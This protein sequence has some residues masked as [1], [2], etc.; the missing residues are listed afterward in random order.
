MLY[1][2]C[3]KVEAAARAEVLHYVLVFGCRCKVRKIFD[4]C[5][6]GC[7]RMICFIS[8]HVKQKSMEPSTMISYGFKSNQ[9][10]RSDLFSL[11]PHG[12]S[13]TSG[14]AAKRKWMNG[15]VSRCHFTIVVISVFANILV[16][17]ALQHYWDSK[18]LMVFNQRCLDIWNVIQVD[19]K[20]VLVVHI[21]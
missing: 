14:S 17:V 19:E 8:T 11:C 7:G 13:M 15:W 4:F 1:S 6:V 3:V 10:S 9:P 12:L 18:M 2:H 5:Q 21:Q 16:P 20:L